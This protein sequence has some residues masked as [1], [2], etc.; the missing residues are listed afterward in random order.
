MLGGDPER[1]AF[2]AGYVAELGLEVWF[3]PY[4]LELTIEAMLP[5]FAECAERAE[6][7]R[8]RGAEV[9]FVLGAELSPMAQGFISGE[10][11]DERVEWLRA[12]GRT[13][14]DFSGISTRVNEFLAE[15]A[16]VVNGRPRSRLASPRTCEAS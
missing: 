16:A 1:L 11:V 4:P 12:P 9:V 8:R 15:A 3:S 10:S 5:L 13:G 14:E 7:L 2:A 6:G